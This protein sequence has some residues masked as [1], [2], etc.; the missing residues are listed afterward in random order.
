MEFLLIRVFQLAT[1]SDKRRFFAAL[2]MTF[3]VTLN[4]V[5][6]LLCVISEKLVLLTENSKLLILFM[7][8]SQ[9][10]NT[11][12]HTKALSKHKFLVRGKI[13]HKKCC[14]GLYGVRKRQL[15]HAEATASALQIYP[16]DANFMLG[17]N[18]Y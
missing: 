11:I 17:L 16:A 7:I 10:I 2:R 1:L 3:Y 4:E 5:K 18:Y 6:G 13:W 8:L 15:S 9:I 14:I 12:K